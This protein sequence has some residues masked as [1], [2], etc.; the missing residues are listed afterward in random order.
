M[1]DGSTILYSRNQD[2]GAPD[3]K[4]VAFMITLYA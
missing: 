4:G 1:A 2:D 3:T